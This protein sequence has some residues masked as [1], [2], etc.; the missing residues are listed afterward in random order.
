MELLLS[1][2]IIFLA[3]I[4][5]G[6]AGF[7]FALLAVPFLS[8]IIPLSQTVPLVVAC[9]TVT[10]IMVFASCRQ[11]V[12]L[13]EISLMTLCGIIGIPIGVYGLIHVDSDILKIIMSFVIIIIALAMYFGFHIHFKNKKLAYSLTGLLSGILNSSIAMSGPPI[14][15][16]LSNEGHSKEQFRANLTFYAIIVNI[17]T[18]ITFYIQGLFD[19]STLYMLGGNL[20]A[21][22]IGGTLGIIICRRINDRK[23]RKLIICL[24]FILGMIKLLQLIT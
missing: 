4:L 13:K 24:L 19:R 21:L 23:F 5:Q 18:I 6:V 8:M 14:V 9:S 17:I 3:S 10:N 7:G 2:L 20:I 12:N 11:H 15:I 1:S 16:F 22:F